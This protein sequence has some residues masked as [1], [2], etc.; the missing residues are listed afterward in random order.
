MN[1]AM[2]LYQERIIFSPTPVF[3]RWTLWRLDVLEL[4]FK[5]AKELYNHGVV[6]I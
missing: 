4:L 3:K 5:T 6:L 2:I 1:S